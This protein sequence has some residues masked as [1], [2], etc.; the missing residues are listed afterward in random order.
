[1]EIES[2]KIKQ[3]NAVE[4]RLLTKKV[5]IDEG[6]RAKHVRHGTPYHARR[7]QAKASP[8]ELLGYNIQ[9]RVFSDFPGRW[10]G[11]LFLKKRCKKN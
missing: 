8:A 4:C 3:I 11:W 6:N 2:S 1:M 5:T 10:R 9:T 7:G